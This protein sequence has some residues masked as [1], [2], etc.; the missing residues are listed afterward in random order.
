MKMKKLS[1]IVLTVFLA[2]AFGCSSSGNDG[3]GGDR[4]SSSNPG[5]KQSA[6]KREGEIRPGEKRNPDGPGGGELDIDSLDIPDQMKEAI[7]SGK[8]PPEQVR[9]MLKKYQG[10]GESLPVSVAPVQRQ[11][12]N[13]YLVLNGI[14]EPE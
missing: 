10:G 5:A 6:E 9:E 4:N 13:S 7:K 3:Q 8:I 2:F 11:D 12:L 14:V 1:V